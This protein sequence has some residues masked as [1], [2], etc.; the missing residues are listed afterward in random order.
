MNFYT[1]SVLS[2]GRL[3]IISFLDDLELLG[4]FRIDF[5]NNVVIVTDL[6]QLRIYLCTVLNILIDPVAVALLYD[7]RP[8]ILP[9][10]VR[11]DDIFIALLNDRRLIP[12]A[13]LRQLNLI[14]PPLLVGLRQIYGLSVSCLVLM[15]FQFVLPALLEAGRLI[16]P[17]GGQFAFEQF[18]GFEQV[19]LGDLM[20]RGQAET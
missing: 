18:A 1:K 3:E 7:E 4:V 12:G 13:V 14:V 5:L 16:A 9:D 20:L 10:N 15:N 2:N 17:P 11:M 19:V 8:V 6:D